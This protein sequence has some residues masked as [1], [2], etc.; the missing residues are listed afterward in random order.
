MKSRLRHDCPSWEIFLCPMEFGHCVNGPMTEKGIGFEKHFSKLGDKFMVA[1]QNFTL[2][3]HNNKQFKKLK[4][5]L[6]K[7]N[8]FNKFICLP[9]NYLS[10]AINN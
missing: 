4:L 5:S 6:H 3:Y 9:T 2:E 8:A 10:G 1:N 7:Q